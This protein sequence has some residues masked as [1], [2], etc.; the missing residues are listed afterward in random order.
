VHWPQLADLGQT[1]L[2]L[3]FYRLREKSRDKGR[4]LEPVT[5]NVSLRPVRLGYLVNPR[6]KQTLRDVMRMATTMWGG[7]MSPLI[8]VMKRL[9]AEWIDKHLSYGPI[10]ISRGY[11]RFFEPDLLV[12]TKAGQLASLGLSKEPSWS[13]NQRFFSLDNLI[14]KDHGLAADLNVGTNICY[15]YQP[16]FKDEFQFKKRVDPVIFHFSEGAP[17]HSFLRGSFRVFSEKSTAILLKK[18]L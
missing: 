7:M 16:L 10:Q 3:L 1:C 14:R 13:A 5:A 9:P 17:R 2:D 11:I 12:R 4:D 8:P 18:Q 15:I 6:E